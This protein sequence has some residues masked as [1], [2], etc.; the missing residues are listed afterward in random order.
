MM[1]TKFCSPV[2][3]KSVFKLRQV[4]SDF[5]VTISVI[6]MVGVDLMIGLNTPKLNVPAT[7]TVS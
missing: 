4:V 2:G 1:K 5:A 7:L 6:V 3:K